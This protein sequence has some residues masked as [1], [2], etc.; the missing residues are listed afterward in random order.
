M[1]KFEIDSI[2]QKE[3]F[4]DEK[5]I[6][7]YAELTGDKNPLHVDKEFVS[8]TKFN[9]CIA[10]AGLMFGFISNTL[11]T[12]FPGPGTVYVYQ[13]LTFLN[14]VYANTRVLVKIIVKELLPKLGAIIQTN[15]IDEEGNSVCSGEAKIKLPE[16]C[17]K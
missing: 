7:A 15:V 17:K 2:F 12:E 6:K 11:G 9:K 4:I 8:H 1:K 3:F 5:L 13:N 14:P 10:H 16:W